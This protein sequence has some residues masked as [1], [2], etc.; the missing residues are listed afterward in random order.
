[1]SHGY[2]HHEAAR[3]TPNSPSPP[4][5][6]QPG[7][8]VA[9][10]HNI[11]TTGLHQDYY[12]E[13]TAK[14]TVA[15]G[16]RGGYY[17]DEHHASPGLQAGAPPV[18]AETK[19]D[20]GGGLHPAAAGG[21]TPSPHAETDAT[22]AAA[23]QK[24]SR[25]RLWIVLGVVAAVLVIVGAVLGGVLGSRAAIASGSNTS[26]SSGDEATAG[27]QGNDTAPPLAPLRFVRP[28]SRLAVTGWREGDDFHIRL[29]FQGP[30][31][32]LRYVSYASAAPGWSARPTL[33]DQLE[34]PAAENTSLAAATSVESKEVV[35]FSCITPPPPFSRH[36]CP[37]D[38]ATSSAIYKRTSTGD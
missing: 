19:Y 32:R 38:R 7:L 27:N 5:Q 37:L 36:E 22:A 28:G 9:P 10:D 30:D 20:D 24:P 6:E 4:Y 3:P 23:G 33:L 25:K 34:F 15:P 16:D 11:D 26:P 1:M 12:T 35:G 8:E 31:Q 18:A 2:N 17:P 14:Q 13:D 29:F 21:A